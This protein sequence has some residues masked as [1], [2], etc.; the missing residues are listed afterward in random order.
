MR[1]ACL[2]VKSRLL[3]DFSEKNVVAT[4]CNTP[5][6]TSARQALPEVAMGG[7]GLHGWTILVQDIDALNAR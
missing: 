6:R 1:T 7:H 5:V 2:P 3:I 4:S